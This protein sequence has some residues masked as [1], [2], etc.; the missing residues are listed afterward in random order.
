MLAQG[1]GQPGMKHQVKAIHNFV[2]T[3]DSP[4]GGLVDQIKQ[5]KES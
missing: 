1:K 3:M 2:Q 5:D 4:R